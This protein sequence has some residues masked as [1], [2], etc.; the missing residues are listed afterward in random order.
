V[1]A[2]GALAF[3]PNATAEK[4][5]LVWFDRQGRELAKAAPPDAYRD[6]ALSPD[7]TRLAYGLQDPRQNT[8]DIWVRDLKRGVSSRLTFDPGD[9]VQPSWSPDGSRIVYTAYHG[10]LGQLRVKSASGAGQDDSLGAA[11]ADALGATDWSRDGHTLLFQR[12]SSTGWDVWSMPLD[13]AR[14]P[15]PFLRTPFNENRGRL[16]PDGKWIAYQSTESGRP[17]VYVQPFPGPGGKWQV[18]NAGG[19]DPKWRA[20][21]RELFYR[22]PGQDLMAV[23]VTAGATFESGT[24]ERLFQKDLES[25]GYVLTRYAVASDGQRFLLNVPVQNTS[26]ASFTVVLNWAAELK[27]K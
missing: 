17:E 25:A 18:S 8:E 4:S 9:E 26:L 19:G 20:D 12:R 27:R 15:V 1:S 22:T 10:S 16:S 5:E 24:P 2:S 7:E 3:M 13:G 14:T 21:G 11:V 23:P 6:L